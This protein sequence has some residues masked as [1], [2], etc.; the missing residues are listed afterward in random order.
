MK[1]NILKGIVCFV[2]TVY[3]AGISCVSVQA[4]ERVASTEAIP[5]AYDSRQYG[6][7]TE[8]KEQYGGACW[9]FAAIAATESSLIK[10]NQLW[11]EIFL[12][13]ITVFKMEWSS[14]RI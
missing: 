7:V 12:C 14:I 8:K 9:A 1:K 11:W 3:A 2:L 5:A 13:G 10:S 6:Y 4:Q